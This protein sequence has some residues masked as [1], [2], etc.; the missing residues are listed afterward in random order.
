MPTTRDAL[1]EALRV[2]KAP[3]EILPGKSADGSS[4]NET[5]PQTQKNGDKPLGVPPAVAPEERM[6]AY[7]SPGE[8]VAFSLSVAQQK[9]I[10]VPT[11]QNYRVVYPEIYNLGGINQIHG[12][13]YDRQTKDVILVGKYD[14]ARQPLTLDDFAVALR[15]RFIHDKWPL[16]SID[17]TEETEKTQLQI[18]R[19]EG[20]IEDTQFGVDLFDA[21]YRLK[22][23]AMGLL[24]SGVPGVQSG[25]DLLSFQ[26]LMFISVI[27]V[28]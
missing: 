12:L 21:D 5:P 25:W 3:L 27:H 26:K 18:V 4:V 11:G 17:P 19:F 1:T 24:P 20:G 6:K 7:P 14:P 9:I 10:G 8:Y 2:A 22:Q 15:A 23:I 13:I 16:V 28:R